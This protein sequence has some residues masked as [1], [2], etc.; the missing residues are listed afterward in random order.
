MQNVMLFHR[1]ESKS[2]EDW[3]RSSMACKAIIF[4]TANMVCKWY[5]TVL[6][7]GSG[8]MA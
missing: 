5:R 4:V 2:D 6:P 3:Q 7:S 1:Y 8:T